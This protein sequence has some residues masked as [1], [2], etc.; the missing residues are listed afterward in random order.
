M[1]EFE[2]TQNDLNNLDIIL[3]SIKV[4]E[5]INSFTIIDELIVQILDCS[6]NDFLSLNN[7]FKNYYNESK[8]IA[9][10]ASRIIQTITDEKLNNSFG[11][12]KE[13]IDNFSK[14][15]NLFTSKVDEFDVEIRKTINKIENLNILHHN[16]V[17][18]IVSIKLLNTKSAID[19]N[20]Y[21]HIEEQGDRIKL[22]LQDVEKLIN[23]FIEKAT[24]I[25]LFLS[26]IKQ[27]NYNQL[28]RLNDNIE[29]SFELFKRKHHEANEMFVKLKEQTDKNATYVANII[30]HLQYHDII[31]QKIEHIQHTHKDIIEELKEYTENTTEKSL[32]HNKAKTY[33]KIRDIS[34]LQAAQLIH[35]NNQYQNAIREISQNL[36]EIGNNM[37]AINSM[38]E[39]LVGRS[40][41]SKKYYLDSIVDNLNLALQYN[42]KLSELTYQLNHQTS[43]LKSILLQLEN[44]FN[45]S[46]DQI[47]NLSRFNMNSVLPEQNNSQ[48]RLVFND[49]HN[50]K[51]QINSILKEL[52]NKIDMLASVSQ[53]FSNEKNFFEKISKTI[54]DLINLLQKSIKDVDEFLNLNSS[55]STDIS[56][57]IKSSI[58]NIKYY[59]I[60]EKSCEKIINELNLINARLNYG[61]QVSAKDREENLKILKSR[62]TMASE[63][64]IHD[65]L[66]SANN[67]TEIINNNSEQIIKIANQKTDEDDDNLELF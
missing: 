29:I 51:L 45:D 49:I 13:V 16:L 33:I 11:Q 56:D 35:A 31:R 9:N 43:E 21:R 27:D 64:L 1:N 2:P 18:N 26:L 50:Q 17:Q 25:N 20:N 15:S 42:Q 63:H 60:F 62:Y 7:H 54:P 23:L 19:P 6:S 36:E 8:N 32:I 44:L 10:N 59:D 46:F 22:K 40:E 67:I 38:C 47:E 4:E 37:V 65:K 66:S 14:L 41:K 34:G 57:D 24:E 48:N 55:K 61:Y 5:A 53:L 3:N 52:T 12:L 30:T 28:Q 39:N 58:R